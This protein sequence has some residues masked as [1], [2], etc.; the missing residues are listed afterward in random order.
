[1][2]DV[3]VGPST[4]A[5]LWL[6]FGLVVA[7]IVAWV[8]SGSAP[9]WMAGVAAGLTAVL[10]VVRSWQAVAQEQAPIMVA[11]DDDEDDDGIT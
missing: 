10:S 2:S 9:V 6:V 1:M 7:F 5:T 3:P 4:K 8:E 11:M